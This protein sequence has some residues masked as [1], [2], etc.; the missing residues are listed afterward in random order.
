MPAVAATSS[1]VHLTLCLTHDCNLRCAYCYGGEKSHRHMAL[2]TARRAVALALERTTARLHLVFFG[3]E[4]LVRWRSLVAMTELARACAARRGIALHPTVTTNGTLLSEP[5]VRWLREHRFVTAVSCD[6]NRAAHDANRRSPAGRS[7]YRRTIAGLQRALAADLSVRVVL[8]V[9]P[10]NVAELSASIDALR[11]LGADDFVVNPNWAA[12][13]SCEQVRQQWTEAYEAVG[14][15]YVEAYRRGRPFWISFIDS[16]I[17]AHIKG[18]YAPEE[19]CDL[20]RR[21]LVVAP[22][23]NLYPCDRLVGEDRD[24]RYVIG[25]VTTGVDPTRLGPLVEGACSL[26]VDCVDCAVRERCRNRCACANVAMTGRVDCPAETLCF[27]E[28]LSIAV[29]DR[30]A[31]QLF[32]EQH[33]AFVRRHYGS[34]VH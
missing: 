14:R 15:S 12:E 20:G 33:E 21:N 23:G 25:H 13:W 7:S 16:K 9:D 3:G 18:G 22:S 34:A 10:S 17:A 4:P 6:G 11:A 29:A 2:A 19:R 8:V 5:R 30:A 1:D 31:E 32:D 27:H 28:Q 26:P 24:V